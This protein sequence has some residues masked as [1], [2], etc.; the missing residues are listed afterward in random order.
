MI[1]SG[2]IDLI[3]LIMHKS[4]MNDM[5]WLELIIIYDKAGYS[6][7]YLQGE[8]EEGLKKFQ[9]LVDENPQD[10]RPYLCQVSHIR[11]TC[12]EINYV[13]SR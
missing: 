8:L 5:L 6:I 11:T 2:G 1:Y 7:V 3:T 9:T 4:E 10:F 12:R 13:L